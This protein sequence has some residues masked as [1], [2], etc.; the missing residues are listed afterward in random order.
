VVFSLYTR[1]GEIKVRGWSLWQDLF[2]LAMR[3]PRASA[4]LLVLPDIA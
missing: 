1:E 2:S 4:D 3:F